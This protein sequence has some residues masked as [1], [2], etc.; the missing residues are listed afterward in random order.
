MKRR[1]FFATVAAVLSAPFGG[2]GKA[3]PV[4]PTMLRGGSLIGK[5]FP[6]PYPPIVLD[7]LPDIRGCD[8]FGHKTHPSCVEVMAQFMEEMEK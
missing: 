1:S 6:N 4:A 7:S 3:A 8:R 2:L 5:S